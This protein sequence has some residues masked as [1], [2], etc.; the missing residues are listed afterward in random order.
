[1]SKSEQSANYLSMKE[2]SYKENLRLEE[3][4]CKSR[5]EGFRECRSFRG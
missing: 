2:E 3:G 1:M 5:R 4:Q